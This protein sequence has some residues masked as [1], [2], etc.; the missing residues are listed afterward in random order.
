MIQ[1]NFN[2]FKNILFSLLIS[3]TVSTAFAATVNDSDI[4]VSTLAVEHMTCSMC[5]ITVRRSLKHV[6]GVID[7]DINFDNKTATVTYH[8]DKVN[9]GMLTKATT[10][11]GYPSS[12]KQ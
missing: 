6:D 2:F 4:K 10:S 12:L 1:Q 9:V 11:A 7:A 5:P 8:S 3:L